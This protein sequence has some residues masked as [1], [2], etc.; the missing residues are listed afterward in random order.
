MASESIIIILLC[1]LIAYILFFNKSDCDKDKTT[2]TTTAATKFSWFKPTIPNHLA[3]RYQQ[4]NPISGNDPAFNPM[5]TPT[6]FSN[7][8]SGN[9]PSFNPMA[10]PTKFS[11]GA[12]PLV[13]ERPQLPPPS[14]V[15]CPKVD[16]CPPMPICPKV[17]PCPSCPSCPG[18]PDC[19]KVS[20]ELNT[21]INTLTNELEL[22]KR[23]CSG[24]SGPKMVT[25]PPSLNPSNLSSLPSPPKTE[26]GLATMFSNNIV[27]NNLATFSYPLNFATKGSKVTM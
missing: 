8:I 5:A 27:R 10:T 13:P 4:P 12:S 9:E 17:N 3:T 2:A 7:P 25:P 18:C 26:P 24:P 11:T 23:L 21:K 20:N 14:Q 19:S 22:T 1:L 6:K 15:I 16:P